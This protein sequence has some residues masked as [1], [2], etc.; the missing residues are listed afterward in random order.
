MLG[1]FGNVPT[2]LLFLWGLFSIRICMLSATTLLISRLTGYSPAG[3]RRPCYLYT[4]FNLVPSF[5]WVFQL[6]G[7]TQIPT[8]PGCC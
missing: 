4:C 3:A 5:V 7:K 2:L 8:P 1:V 6:L